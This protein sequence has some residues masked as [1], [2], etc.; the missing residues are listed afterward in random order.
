MLLGTLCGARVITYTATSEV[1]GK[2]AD[3]QALA[4]I[5]SQIRVS[6]SSERALSKSE[7]RGQKTSLEK[8][9]AETIRTSSDVLLE[10]VELQRSRSTKGWET[11]ATFDTEKVTAPLRNQMR[12]LLRDAVAQDSLLNVALES[13]RFDGI[14]SAWNRLS[15]ILS[16]YTRLVEKVLLLE[17]LA[18]EENLRIDEMQIL[19]KISGMISSLEISFA[20][21]ST[22]AI[23]VIVKK[24]GR[25]IAGV[26]VVSLLDRKRLAERETDS[27]GIAKF[28]TADF[29]TAPGE[30]LVSFRIALPGIL[31]DDFGQNLPAEI[32]KRLVSNAKGCA[33]KLRC[34]AEPDVC[35]Q[36][37]EA[38]S[39]AGFVLEESGKNIQ[40][41]IRENGR[42]SFDGGPKNLVR[43]E[44]AVK[45]SNGSFEFSKK[46]LG[47]GTS[48]ARAKIDAVRKLRP[49][50]IYDEL[51]PVCEGK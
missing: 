46:V 7:V 13:V 40:V 30:H 42:K 37:R 48:E 35:S 36:L 32:S 45:F 24:S 50:A 43:M 23:D 47:T 5:A 26:K 14:L 22:E 17:P 11:T 51:F 28:L 20:D 29:K 15:E 41:Q 31:Q 39:L 6:V 10:H 44:F 16:E 3:G 8:K 33:L 2:D 25:P 21:S 4:G 49:S 18:A 27:S 12:N 1:S 19:E 9:Y 38:L 34:P